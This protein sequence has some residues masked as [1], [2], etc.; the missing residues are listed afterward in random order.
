[1]HSGRVSKINIRSEPQKFRHLNDTNIFSL[2]PYEIIRQGKNT[3]LKTYKIIGS[4]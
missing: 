3:F 4:A 1:M 2:S